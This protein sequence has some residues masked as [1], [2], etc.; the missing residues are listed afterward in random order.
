MPG[1]A[2]T[3]EKEIELTELASSGDLSAAQ[4]SIRLGVSRN[5]VIAKMQRMSIPSLYNV[6]LQES[7]FKK[8][9]LRKNIKKRM[10]N[11]SSEIKRTKKMVK[12]LNPMNH[13][14]FNSP[15]VFSKKLAD[16]QANECRWPVED[17]GRVATLFCAKHTCGNYCTEHTAISIDTKKNISIPEQNV[18]IFQ[19]KPINWASYSRKPDIDLQ[20]LPISISSTG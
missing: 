18:K 10:Y 7:S 8:A 9:L 1:K 2:W 14:S 20:N 4:M 19:F 6:K 13:P 11:F 15:N 5:S 12:N 16:L 17:N 3:R